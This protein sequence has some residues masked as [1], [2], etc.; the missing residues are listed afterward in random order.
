[1]GKKGLGAIFGARCR[2]YGKQMT[3]YI[4]AGQPIVDCNIAVSG[5]DFWS[6]D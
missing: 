1:M 2:Y 5:F 6:Y 4:L 3:G